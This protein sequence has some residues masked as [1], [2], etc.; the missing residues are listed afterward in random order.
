M[1]VKVSEIP[2]EGLT[3]AER[4]D[5]VQMKLNMDQLKFVGPVAVIASFEKQKDAVWVRVEAQSR[6]E[7]VCDR[8]LTP[9]A[10][11]Y[12]ESFDLHYAV[13]GKQL[14]D[15][16][17]DVRQEIL[18]SYPARFLC[19][20]ACKGLCARCGANLNEGDCACHVDEQRTANRK[21]DHEG[22]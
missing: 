21:T 8:C 13:R 1:K 16:T 9:F 17:D 4:M 3:L 15:V 19:K 7:L 5:P 10:R 22:F 18:L 14:L 2:E 11:T 20:E 6:L 12:A